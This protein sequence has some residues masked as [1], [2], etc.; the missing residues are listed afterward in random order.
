MGKAAGTRRN[1]G[2]AWPRQA[3][4]A[5]GSAVLVATS[6]CAEG[7]APGRGIYHGSSQSFFYM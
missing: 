3:A 2:L 5:G 1:F 7:Q 4:A 6:A